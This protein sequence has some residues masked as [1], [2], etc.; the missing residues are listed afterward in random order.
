MAEHHDEYNDTFVAGLEWMWGEGF[1]S[2]GGPAEVAAILDGVD[3]RGK[4]VLDI[5]CGI[6]GID[7]LLIKQHGAVHV[8]GIDVE[9]SLVER[10]RQTVHT[11][12]V[13][14]RVSIQLVTPGPYLPF[15]D[16]MF[17]VVF[18]KDSIIH[19]PEKEVIYGEMFRVLKS[20]GQIAFSDWYGSNLPKTP[21]FEAWLDVLGLTFKMAT[22]EETAKLM[23]KIGF[24]DVGLADRNAWYA[25]N[26]LEELASIEGQNYPKLIDQLG[27]TA[28]GQRL[29]SSKLKKQ[30]VDQG[31]LRPGHIRGRKQ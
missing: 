17:D 24:V 21:E 7:I 18:S 25:Q 10:A 9:A 2:P 1:M 28:A 27:E 14:D 13:S 3:L 31:L 8:T 16:K 19:I 29:K 15:M 4:R 26:M 23:Q 20:G 5:G 11:A 12:G 6:G 30:V 22:L